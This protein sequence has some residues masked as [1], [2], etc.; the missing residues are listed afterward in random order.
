MA[1]KEKKEPEKSPSSGRHSKSP[2]I[3]SA[4]AN[5]LDLDRE[6]S[7]GRVRS[8]QEEQRMMGRT[9]GDP[10]TAKRSSQV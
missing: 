6:P 2:S 8:L 10:V 3:G 5:S 4:S 1:S 7:I 9:P